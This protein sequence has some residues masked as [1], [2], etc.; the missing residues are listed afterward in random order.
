MKADRNK[1]IMESNKNVILEKVVLFKKITS[2]KKFVD[3]I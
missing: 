2:N 1:K 3:K